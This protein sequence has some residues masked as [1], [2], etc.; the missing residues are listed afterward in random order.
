M[1]KVNVNYVK[2]I[3]VIYI[4]AFSYMLLYIYIY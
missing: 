4:I 3:P 2:I 1:A